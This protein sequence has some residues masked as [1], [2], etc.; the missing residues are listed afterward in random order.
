MQ[1]AAI[2]LLDPDCA[3][4][5]A[6]V[7]QEEFAGK[8]SLMIQRLQ[9]MGLPL[10]NQPL[11]AFYCFAKLAGLPPVLQD[12]MSFFDRALQEKVITVPGK[13]FDVNPGNRRSRVLCES[14]RP[15]GVCPMESG[16][17]I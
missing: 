3:D 16:C 6:R 4:T 15:Q 17:Y 8:R 11:G 13:F 1:K 5:A 9:A 2:P 10:P 7:I 12:G 14:R